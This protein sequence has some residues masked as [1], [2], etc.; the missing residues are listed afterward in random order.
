MEFLPYCVEK[1]FKM[2][3]IALLRERKVHIFRKPRKP[4]EKPQ[5]SASIKCDMIEKAATMQARQRY[6][7]AN[8]LFCVCCCGTARFSAICG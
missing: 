7:L 3:V 5:A 4:M 2:N 8:L 1:V 6:L